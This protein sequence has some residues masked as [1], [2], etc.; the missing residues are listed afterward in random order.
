[1]YLT[2]LPRGAKSLTAHCSLLT[3]HC[4]L[5]TAHCSLLTAHCSLLTDGVI[6]GKNIIHKKISAFCVLSAS[7]VRFFIFKS[8]SGV[9]K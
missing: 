9:T 2:K 8:T 3:A 6:R 5:L 1:M 7:G 4:S